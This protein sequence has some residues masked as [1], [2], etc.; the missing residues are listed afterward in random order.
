MK[1][2]YQFRVGDTWFQGVMELDDTDMVTVKDGWVERWV[3]GV[4]HKD[5][6]FKPADVHMIRQVVKRSLFAATQKCPK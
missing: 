4:W 5:D 6:S 3:R 2:T 1:E